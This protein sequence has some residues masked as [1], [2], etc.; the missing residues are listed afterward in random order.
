VV[1]TNGVALLAVLTGGERMNIIKLVKNKPNPIDILFHIVV[2]LGIGF[3]YGFFE[4]LFV[5]MVVT[6]LDQ[7]L[8]A[9]DALLHQTEKEVTNE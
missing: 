3:R 5:F 2:G 7:I 1:V 4:G 9:I 6:A 8:W